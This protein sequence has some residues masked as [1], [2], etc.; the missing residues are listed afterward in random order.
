MA[1]LSNL[2]GLAS[3]GAL[4]KQQDRARREVG[5]SAVAQWWTMRL[6][7]QGVPGGQMSTRV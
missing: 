2:I 5:Q 4:R 1:H 7:G 3:G 6:R